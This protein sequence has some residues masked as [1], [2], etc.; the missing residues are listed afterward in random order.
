MYAPVSGTILEQNTLLE[1]NSY[2]LNSSPYKEGW[3]YRIEPSNW[4][5][6][7]QLLFMADKQKEFIARE[8]GRLKDFLMKSLGAEDST[9]AQAVL[10]DGGEIR[11]GV[12]SEC[13]P[14]IWEDFQTNFI[15]PSRQFW[16]YEM[17]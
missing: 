3:I 9:Y 11:D 7:C 14:E 15:D 10:A 2:V 17:F 4:S 13:G 8:F 16:F 1:D 12:L 6:E 5:R